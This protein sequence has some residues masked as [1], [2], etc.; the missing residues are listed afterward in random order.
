VVGFAIGVGGEVPGE[1][2]PMIREHNNNNNNNNNKLLFKSV[3]EHVNI[4]AQYH[5]IKDTKR[6]RDCGK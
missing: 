1:G 4:A 2:K 6:K 3:C 5:G